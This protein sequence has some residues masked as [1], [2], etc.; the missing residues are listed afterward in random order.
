M[1]GKLQRTVHV[2]RQYSWVGNDLYWSK[3]AEKIQVDDETGL[4]VLKPRF[5]SDK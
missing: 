5:N 1:A 4:P 2:A 3:M